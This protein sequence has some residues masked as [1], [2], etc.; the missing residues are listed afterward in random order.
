MTKRELIRKLI[1]CAQNGDTEAAHGDA[2]D[3]L[4]AFIDDPEIETAY[5]EVEKWYA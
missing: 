1:E 4:I 3:A 2:D 5:R